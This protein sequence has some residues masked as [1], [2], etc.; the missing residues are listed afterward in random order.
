[1]ALLLE[2][3][4]NDRVSAKEFAE[5]KS[6]Y[7]ELLIRHADVSDFIENASMPLHW[8]D[9]HGII[10]WANR[11]ELELLGYS[12][13]E[14]IGKHIASFH[15]DSAVIEDILGRLSKNDTL[16]DYP[17]RLKHRDGTIRHVLINS[18]V[19]R[20]GDNF[21]HTRCFMRDVT[22][23]EAER[24]RREEML[25]KL[26]ESESRLRLAI[27]STDLGNWDWD[28][29]RGN[30]YWSSECK[31]ILGLPENK[32]ISFLE[33]LQRMQVED[34]R[35][36][37][38]IVQDIVADSRSARIDVV[39]RIIRFKDNA[40]R[41]IRIQGTTMRNSNGTLVRVLGTLLDITDSVEAEQR[42]AYLA[43]IITSSDDAIVAKTMD[44]VITNWNRGAE[45]I[46]G[47][48][49][50]EIVGKS[51]MALIPTDRKEEE[52]YI[53]T[54][55]GRGRSVEHYE[56]KRLTKGG[57]MID[58]SLTISPI[59]DASGNILGISKVARDITE[60]KQE[61]KRKNDFV[62]VVSHE[63]KTPL[64]SILL[65]T[66]LLGKK[67]AAFED[68]SLFNM[69]TKI[70]GYVKRMI[71]MVA[72]YLG[73]SKIEEGKVDLNK[74][75]FAFG[76]LAKEITEEC[77]FIT[78]KHQIIIEG[79][80]HVTVCADREKIRQVLINLVNNAVKYSPSGGKV[81]L[82]CRTSAERTTIYV[83]DEGMGIS[84]SNQQ[85]LFQRFYRV[86]NDQSRNISGF[87]IGLYLV[88]ELLKLH[89]SEIKVQ[90]TV[91]KGSVFYFDL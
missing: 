66:Q 1:M 91:G 72:D 28:K 36:I 21:V 47:Y 87:G 17:A 45:R 49:A 86:D 31:R 69:N 68:R 22:Q 40:P 12:R 24:V 41:T 64:T 88:S 43:A 83:E 10:S 26:Q 51:I 15:A 81:T 73:L 9:E 34:R 54:Q 7:Q 48:R 63:L 89:D 90:S 67:I 44:G 80:D 65:Y 58:V 3:M 53:L 71:G 27:E 4:E 79:C 77:G 25:V 6:K 74:N 46:F 13:E 23:M 29:R 75:E 18:N 82:G 37:D 55:L 30:I 85:R 50:D 20:S 35:L 60:R 8:V 39:C 59:K 62:A 84:E 56:T 76:P 70:E 2:I 32:S 38:D 52:L 57:T 5:L 11:A 14:Y 19:Q 78:N 42:N 61:E 16:L 33:F